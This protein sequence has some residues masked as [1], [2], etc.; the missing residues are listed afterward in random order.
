MIIVIDFLPNPSSGG[1]AI[2]CYES[3]QRIQQNEVKL[4][5]LNNSPEELDVTIKN[6]FNITFY[7]VL[8]DLISDLNTKN[9]EDSISIW[10]EEFASDLAFNGLKRNIILKVGDPRLKVIL[11]RLR[12]NLFYSKLSLRSRIGNIYTT[13][14]EVIKILNKLRLLKKL[15]STLIYTG[16]QNFRF[17]KRNLNAKEY[18]VLSFKKLTAPNN[19]IIPYVKRNN[20]ILC[21]GKLGQIENL[22]AQKKMIAYL[23]EI[24]KEVETI[25]SIRIIG[26]PEGILPKLELM[27]FKF[28]RLKIEGFIDNLDEVLNQSKILWIPTETTLGVRTRLY[29][30]WQ[31]GIIVIAHRSITTGIPEA[32]SGHNCLLYNSKQELIKQLEFALSQDKNILEIISN[33]IKENTKIS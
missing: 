31:F 33:G 3:L 4:F 1:F 14:R 26:N 20:D 17:W 9:S 24:F 11:L 30:A 27:S 25:Q 29:K 18:K 28:Q 2:L 15:V 8:N 12:W 32:I 10:G 19:T 7:S 21:I 23:P 13:L 5:I 6:N 22:F 16:P